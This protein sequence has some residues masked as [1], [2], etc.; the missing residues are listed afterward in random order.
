MDLI[1]E[2][3]LENMVNDLMIVFF[4]SVESESEWE[5]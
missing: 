4:M 5:S 1:F 3:M 2:L